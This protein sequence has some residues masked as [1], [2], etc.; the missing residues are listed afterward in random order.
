MLGTSTCNYSCT[1][2]GRTRRTGRALRGTAL[3]CGLLLGASGTLAPAASLGTPASC[4]G[5]ALRPNARDAASVAAAT[6]CLIDRIR[7][8]HHLRPLQSNRALGRV[9][10]SQLSSMLSKDYFADVRPSGQ[11]PMSL[12]AATGYRAHA[13]G[14]SVGETLAWGTGPYAT[15]THIVAE[16][17]ASPPHREL[18]LAGDFRDAGVA[19][20]AAVPSVLARGKCGATY[21]IELGVR[22]F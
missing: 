12:V 15:P 11:T 6:L 17:M 10:A 5:V 20:T 4:P 8:A 2:L 9:A 19:V 3:L 16:W 7:A 1:L 21:A 14:F 22:W 18:I 13:A